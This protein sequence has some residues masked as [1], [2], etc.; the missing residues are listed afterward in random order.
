MS[1]LWCG[2]VSVK[3][4]GSGAALSQKVRLC[5]SKGQM[6]ISFSGWYTMLFSKSTSLLLWEEP[7]GS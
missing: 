7:S 4:P 3:P 6:V 1:N 5:D 2:E